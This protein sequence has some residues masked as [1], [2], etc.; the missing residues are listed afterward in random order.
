VTR[1]SRN[2]RGR[3]ATKADIIAFEQLRDIGG[4]SV[5]VAAN[6]VGLSRS[7]GYLHE[8]RRREIE[9]IPPA[10]KGFR[11]DEGPP[12]ETQAIGLLLTMVQGPSTTEHDFKGTFLRQLDRYGVELI[13]PMMRVA[14]FLAELRAADLQAS[15][16][17]DCADSADVLETLTTIF[18][19]IN[20]GQSVD[21][22]PSIPQELDT[23]W[24]EWID[25]KAS[26]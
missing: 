9:K 5:E 14:L 23:Y 6:K 16:G 26:V 25:E 10:G 2:G 20:T 17:E 3:K 19:T 12:T 22:H 13:F 8:A 1:Y 11:Q 18:E 7:W 24:R 4:M 15:H 21:G